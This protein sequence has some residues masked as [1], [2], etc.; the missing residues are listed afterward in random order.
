MS[1][2]ITEQDGLIW[3]ENGTSVKGTIEQVKALPLLINAL[4]EIADRGP[5]PGY[6]SESAL[7]LRLVATQS[8]ARAALEET[9][10]K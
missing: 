2:Y 1:T 5:V 7:R 6:G 4:E 10:N 8:I 3:F 9:T